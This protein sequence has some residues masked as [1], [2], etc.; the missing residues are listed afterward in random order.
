VLM[1]LFGFGARAAVPLNLVI[2]AVTLA[3]ALVSRAGTLSLAPVQPHLPEVAGL[4]LGGIL[5]AVLSARLLTSLSDRRIER[6]V[7]ML[8]A[9]IGG[10][11]LVE[12]FVP[13][14]GDGL[15][16]AGSVWRLPVA[17]PLG[18]AIGAVA[19]LLGVAGGELL[20]PTL[21]FVFGADIR[22]AGTAALMISLVTVAAGLWR[23]ARLGALPARSVIS[24]TAV[25]MGLGSILGAA[26]GALLAGVVATTWLKLALGLL[27]LAA[28]AK[29]LRRH[30]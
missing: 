8:L 20:I 12:A 5:G 1:G 11:L 30:G 15:L 6:L 19:A 21:L 4:A 27:L 3:A 29:A 16:A 9:G 24:T 26:V 25:P 18:A 10:L 22:A 14:S 17:V 2:S 28:A 23:Y 7:A 13:I